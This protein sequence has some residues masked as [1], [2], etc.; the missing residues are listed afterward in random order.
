MTAWLLPAATVAWWAGL[1]GGFGP[2]RAWPAWIPAVLGLAMLV[3][4]VIGAPAMRRSDPVADAGL[5]PS[6]RLPADAVLRVSAP[7]RSAGGPALGVAALAL[8]GVCGLG[9]A[10]ALLAQQRIQASPL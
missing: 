9:A 7:R 10:W 1:L 4:A 2:M 6:A 8:T 3:A 5:V